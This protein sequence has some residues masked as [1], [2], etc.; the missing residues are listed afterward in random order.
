MAPVVKILKND[1]AFE[2]RVCLT[3]QHR[4][5]IDQLMK[6]F[7][8][9]VDYDLDIMAKD[10]TLT[11]ITC[12][13][14]TG[15]EGIFAKWKPDCILVQGDT[16]SSFSASLAAFYHKINVG[17]IEAGLRTRN[18]YSPYPEEMNRCLTS[19]LAS[20]HFAPTERSRQNLLK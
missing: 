3:G 6:I 10:Q 9:K 8:I 5:M 2:T 16:T 18:R 20:V 12:K 11:N 14:L 13:V 1:N 4:E 19:E 15:L 7:N 17:H